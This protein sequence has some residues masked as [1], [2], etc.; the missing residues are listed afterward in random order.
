MVNLVEQLIDFIKET[1]ETGS[2]AHKM[3]PNNIQYIHDQPNGKRS[4]AE[5]ASNKHTIIA[6]GPAKRSARLKD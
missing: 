5:V 4:F 6:P 1:T 2:V 3:A